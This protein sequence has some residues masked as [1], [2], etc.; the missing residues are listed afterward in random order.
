ME[1]Q[2]RVKKSA[3]VKRLRQNCSYSAVLVL[4]SGSRGFPIEMGL[5]VEYVVIQGTLEGCCVTWWYR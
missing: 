1:L 5:K 2:G 3:K 4:V